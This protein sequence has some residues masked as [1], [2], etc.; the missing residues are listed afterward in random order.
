MMN[1]LIG[2]TGI[3]FVGGGLAFLGIR[4]FVF[5]FVFRKHPELEAGVTKT[6]FKNLDTCAAFMAAAWPF[7]IP[8]WL[9][10]QLMGGRK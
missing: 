3:Y 1:A 8:M 7:L 2:L 4:Y 6:A 9:V 5:P 10:A